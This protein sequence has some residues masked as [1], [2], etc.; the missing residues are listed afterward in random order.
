MNKDK[1][2]NNVN[3]NTVQKLIEA[4]VKYTRTCAKFG[5]TSLRCTVI[6]TEFT[7]VIHTILHLLSLSLSLSLSHTHTHT[8]LFYY[9][10]LL[11]TS[12]FDG[13]FNPY[14]ANVEYRVSS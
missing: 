6:L 10:P 7:V 8:H 5:F 2:S 3:A 4:G 12:D 9:D 13:H 11:H 1:R 14:P